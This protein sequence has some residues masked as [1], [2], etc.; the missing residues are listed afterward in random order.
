MQGR[1]VVALCRVEREIIKFRSRQPCAV[2][3]LRAAVVQIDF[4]ITSLRHA[5]FPLLL[6]NAVDV[7][8]VLAHGAEVDLRFVFHRLVLAGEHR[9]HIAAIERIRRRRKTAQFRERGHEIEIRQPVVRDSPSFDGSGPPGKQGNTEAA[10]KGGSLTAAQ[11]T[12]ISLVPGSVVAGEENQRILAQ[13][14]AL[15]RLNDFPG[16]EVYFCDG[17]SYVAKRRF[18]LE[19]FRGTGRVMRVRKRHVKEK[20][21]FT[22]LL[23]DA[24]RFLRIEPRELFALNVRFE[25]LRVADQWERLHINA[26]RNSV[27]LVEAA[28]GRK[29]LRRV[30]QMPFA[31]GQSLVTLGMEE[32]GEQRFI[33]RSSRNRVRP[34]RPGRAVACTITPGKQ[35]G[36]RCRADGMRRI[37]MSA[38]QAM[39]SHRVKVGCW[40]MRTVAAEIAIAQIIADHQD[41]IRRALPFAPP[42]AKLGRRPFS[43]CQRQRRDG[44]PSGSSYGG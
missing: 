15:N 1:Y 37:E 42:A 25:N 17:I 8:P 26:V 44:A 39:G 40:Q 14:L 12:G 13:A 43:R 28:I 23:D 24:S 30:S 2:V 7:H 31:N 10:F 6:A 9:R 20:W 22:L 33:Q 5:Q 21:L 11:H 38:A 29:I 41:Y 4:S 19:L 34:E 27:E 16:T 32:I 18:A 3:H 35:S 36:T